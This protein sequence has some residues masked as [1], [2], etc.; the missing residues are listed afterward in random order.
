M[1][2]WLRILFAEGPR[3]VINALTLYSVMQLNLLPTGENEA[4]D[5]RAPVAQFFENVRILTDEQG[6]EQAA[7][8]FAMLFTL[9]IWLI[10]LINLMVAVVLYLL[11]LFHH[12]PSSDG[13]L[14]GYCRRK[15][16]KSMEAIVNTKVE[17]ALR[18]ESAL[19]ARQEAKEGADAINRQPTL[20][21]LDPG[22]GEKPPL[23]SRQ[24]TGTTLPEYNSRPGT[25]AG[26]SLPNLDSPGF[27]PGPLSRV[28]TNASSASW[29]SYGSKAPLIGGAG[30]MG[31]GPPGR[32]QSPGAISPPGSSYAR[33]AP[34][35]SY[36]G[37]SQSSQLSYTPGIGPRPSIGQNGRPVP[38]PYQ[39]E[40]VSRPSTA[41]GGRQ[42]PGAAPSPVDPYGRGPPGERNNPYFPPISDTSGRSTPA[43]FPRANTPG[44]TS[45][46][47]YP[48]GAHSSTRSITPAAPTYG[49]SY[50]PGQPPLARLH[51]NIS[52]G[53]DGYQSSSANSQIPAQFSS[54]SHTPYR[55]YTPPS[56]SMAASDQHGRQTPYTSQSGYAAYQPPGHMPPTQRP[57]TATLTD[58]QT[59][60][61]PDHEMEDILNTY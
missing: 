43:A 35:R 29:G 56:A 59:T 55:P 50:T 48:S 7:I 49:R 3:Q 45:M 27:R 4:K 18:K 46:R 40:P 47:S 57:D 23:L 60:S 16:N 11:F 17:K 10:T 2:A 33:S 52:S 58:R 15:M 12:I 22:S 38:G 44:S 54:T 9:V 31:Q 5:G 37:Y 39:I 19:Q 32:L 13:G 25:S 30:G 26:S 34:N 14:S 24:T 51:T 36:T 42:T 28:D 8:L 21:S 20:P 6:R 61:I 53:D 41:M 1:I